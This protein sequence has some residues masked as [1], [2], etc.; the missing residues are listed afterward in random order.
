MNDCLFGCDGA[1]GWFRLDEGCVAFPKV[2]TQVLCWQHAGS[3][4]GG[5]ALCCI[6]LAQDLTDGWF[7]R[8]WAS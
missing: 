2:H 1:V 3:A 8:W 7:G 6:E 4:R 5:G